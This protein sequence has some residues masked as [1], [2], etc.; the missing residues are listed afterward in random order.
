MRTQD[1]ER[2]LR[3][4]AFVPTEFLYYRGT[5]HRAIA[6]KSIDQGCSLFALDLANKETHIT[7]YA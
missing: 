6:T 5:Q 1:T 4:H 7:P 2:R 3:R